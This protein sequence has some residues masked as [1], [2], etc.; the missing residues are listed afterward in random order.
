MCLAYASFNMSMKVSGKF[1]SIIRDMQFRSSLKNRTPRKRRC[2]SMFQTYLL[3]A[4]LVFLAPPSAIS[5]ELLNKGIAAYTAGDYVQAVKLLQEA[6]RRDFE[7][8][9]LHYYMASAFVRL[10]RNQEAIQ[11]YK[12]ALDLN[13]DGKLAEYCRGAL[14]ILVPTPVKPIDSKEKIAAP[15]K[16]EKGRQ[17]GLQQPNSQQPIIYAYLDGSPASDRA[18][19]I[20]SDLHTKYGDKINFI[21]SYKGGTSTALMSKYS[22]T[23]FPAVFL[24]DGQGKMI[25]KFDKM[26]SEE[27]LRKDVALLAPTTDMTRLTDTAD[28]RLAMSRKA[29]VDE[30]NARVA[31]GRRLVDDAMK[32][33]RREAENELLLRSGRVAAAERSE[34]IEARALDKTNQLR[35]EFD[36]KKREW[37]S[38]VRKRLEGLGIKDSTSIIAP[39]VD[40]AD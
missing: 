23:D 25:R 22:V 15:P 32:Q 10:K 40:G 4:G 16:I 12:L 13:P 36:R 33:A 35:Q 26:F 11:E 7:N 14:N 28:K 39:P 31:D 34:A 1:R 5:S 19:P 3:T 24:F 8:A 30:Y 21:R 29:I 9:N 20:L 6:K 2:N 37:Y 18:I 38:D 27:L 17:P